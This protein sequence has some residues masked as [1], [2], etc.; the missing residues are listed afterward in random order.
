M[1]AGWSGKCS[2][3]RQWYTAIPVSWQTR[4]RSLS[5]TLT[6]RWMV[7]STRRPGTDVSRSRASAS[8]SRRSCGMSFSAQTYRC[9]AASSTACWRSVVVSIAM[10]A[11]SLLGCG[12]PRASPEN[13]TF[14]KAVAHHAVAPVRASRDLAAGVD[15]LERRLGVRV[16]DET[17]VLVV[18]DRVREDRLGQRVDSRRA[19]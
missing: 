18:E 7:S 8:A 13:G 11:P 10:S 2:P 3:T 17:A 4:L 5:A 12:L 15:A 6:L 1:R 19:V 16:D 14:E 9:A